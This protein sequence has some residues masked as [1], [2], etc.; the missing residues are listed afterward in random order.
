MCKN[1][2]KCAQCDGNHHS[3]DNQC[4]VIKEYKDQL[5][6][7]VEDAIQK[8]LLQR[9]SLQEKSPMFEF[10]DQDF[11]PLTTSD[12]HSNKRWNIALPHTTVESNF[13]RSSDTEKA[14][15]S[16]ND[17]LAKLIDSNKR[18]ENKVDLLSTSTKT[19]T[20]DTQ[21]HQAVLADIINI[22]KDFVQYFIPATLTSGK[23]E[24]I[25]LVPVANE[26]YSRFHFGSSRLINGFQL[27]HQVQLIPTSHNNDIIKTDQH[28]TLSRTSNLDVLAKAFFPALHNYLLNPRDEAMH[29][30]KTW[31]FS[32]KDQKLVLS[33]LDEWYSGRTL[34]T[35]LEEWEQVGIASLRNQKE[36][37]K[38]LCYNVEGWGTR[39]VEAIDLAHEVQVS[40]CIFTEVGELWSTC[41]LPHFNKFY[42]KGTNKNGGVCIAVGK[43]L[44]ATRIEVNIPNTVIIDITGLSEPVRIIGIYW[45][46]SQQRDL[47]EI[48]PFVIE[49][50]I[51]SG[52]FNGTVKEW[53][54]PITDRR[55]A[56]VREWINENNLNYITSTTNTSKRFL[57]NIDLSFSNMSTI[58]SETLCSG[59]SDH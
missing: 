7:D 57:R 42:Q 44:K 25:S 51:L 27:N 39:A 22:M 59:T 55:G 45:P 1:E 26:Y 28:R 58:S 47:D 18:L 4:Q 17:N 15:E 40:V 50:T 16:I 46:T 36:Y 54:S 48:Q 2:P 23:S 38:I 5:K 11:P 56:S 41:R 10:R 9:L 14:F 12:N 52:D 32:T 24:R 3:L 31:N 37:I 53:N 29:R 34:N 35:I 21:L 13:L 30:L 33:L 6:E 20:L 49:G 8:G 19:V 43:H